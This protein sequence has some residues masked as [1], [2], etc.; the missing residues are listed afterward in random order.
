MKIFFS[1]LKGIFNV[2]DWLLN[3]KRKYDRKN[4]YYKEKSLGKKIFLIVEMVAIPLLVLAFGLFVIPKCQ[5]NPVAAIVAILG[6][7]VLGIA[8]V[9]FEIM[10][11]ILGFRNMIVSSFEEHVGNALENVVSQNIEISENGIEIKED[12]KQTEEF[13][14]IKEHNSDKEIQ[15]R[16]RKIDLA[17]GILGIVMTAAFIGLAIFV[18][19]KTIPA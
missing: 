10:N 2:F 14:E 3:Y 17:I 4:F 13:G 9:E 7:I 5:S 18:G 1:I 16:C 19:T 8:T 11:S 12:N 15:K 6:Y